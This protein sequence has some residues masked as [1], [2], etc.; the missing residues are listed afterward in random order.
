MDTD[1]KLH[2]NGTVAETTAE[3]LASPTEGHGS[4]ES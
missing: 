4:Q 1:R 3:E 2:V